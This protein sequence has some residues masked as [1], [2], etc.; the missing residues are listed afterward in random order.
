MSVLQRRGVAFIL[1]DPADHPNGKEMQT[2]LEKPAL[3]RNL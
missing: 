2:R 1:L 3:C